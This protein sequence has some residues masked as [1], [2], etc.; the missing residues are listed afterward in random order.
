MAQ[1]IDST[2]RCAV[3]WNVEEASTFFAALVIDHLRDGQS[4]LRS[5][6][7]DVSQP[8]AQEIAQELQS[9]GRLSRDDITNSLI[10]IPSERSRDRFR[11]YADLAY[12][13]GGAKAVESVGILPQENL[14]RRA[15]QVSG[16]D[17]VHRGPL[18]ADSPALLAGGL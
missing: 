17:A 10:R 6:L 7:P 12:Y 4:F 16:I 13:I 14:G 8:L 3:Q 2:A 9:S 5:M 11:R 15:G 18:R 1:F